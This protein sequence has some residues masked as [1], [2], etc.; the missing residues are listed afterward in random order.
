MV[1]ATFCKYILYTVSVRLGG[2][3]ESKGLYVFIVEL[4]TQFF[5]LFTYFAFFVVVIRYYGLPLHIIHDLMLTIATFR[6]RLEAFRT[7][8]RVIRN[9][10]NTYAPDGTGTGRYICFL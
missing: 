10:E 4:T 1:F 7:Y 6:E 5:Q 9:M 2:R 8:L 3:F